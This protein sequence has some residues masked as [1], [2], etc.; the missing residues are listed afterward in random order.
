MTD[1]MR[2]SSK[3]TRH[4]GLFISCA[5]KDLTYYLSAGLQLGGVFFHLLD[6]HICF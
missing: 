3:G 6:S 4:W 2:D 1:M 5:I